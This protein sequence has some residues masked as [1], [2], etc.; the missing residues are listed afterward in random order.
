[1][2]PELDESN[3]SGY[4]AQLKLFKMMGKRKIENKP[5]FT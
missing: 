3:Q 2:P 5:I 4:N 1:V